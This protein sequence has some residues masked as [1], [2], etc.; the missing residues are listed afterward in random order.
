MKA[1]KFII[2]G[3]EQEI[4]QR[5]KIKSIAIEITS[6]TTGVPWTLT[7]T[8]DS[9]S[10][11]VDDLVDGT[12]IRGFINTSIWSSGAGKIIIDWKEFGTVWDNLAGK[13]DDGDNR[14]IA[15]IIDWMFW[16]LEVF[17]NQTK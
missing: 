12:Y 4:P 15:R 2:N 1:L 8:I 17:T 6:Y 14:I 13:D 3:E 11:S 10:W 5:W 7:A 9:Q 16:I